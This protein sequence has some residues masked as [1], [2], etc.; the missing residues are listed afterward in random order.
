MPYSTFLLL[1]VNNNGQVV[2]LSSNIT[3]VSYVLEDWLCHA[4][5]SNRTDTVHSYQEIIICL[6]WHGL[7]K[8]HIILEI[9]RNAEWRNNNLLQDFKIST[10]TKD[11]GISGVLRVC[12]VG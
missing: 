1:K 9:K 11:M 2:S 8:H 5:F 12:G 10:F 6:E 7:C 3:L 4:V